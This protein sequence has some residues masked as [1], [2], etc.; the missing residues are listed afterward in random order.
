MTQNDKDLV[1]EAFNVSYKEYGKVHHM[2]ELADSEETKERLRNI[3]DLLY[4]V[5]LGRL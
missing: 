3:R 1:L 2:I 5:Y 4:D